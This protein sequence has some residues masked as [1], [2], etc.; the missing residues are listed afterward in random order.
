MKLQFVAA[1]IVSLLIAVPSFA[2]GQGYP[3]GNAK[4]GQTIVVIELN[5]ISPALVAEIFGGTV[6]YNTPS[7]SRGRGGY[8]DT[9]SGQNYNRNPRTTGRNR[10]NATGTSSLGR[11]SGSRSFDW[12]D[13]RFDW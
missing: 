7:G 9:S 13:S 8:G 12:G 6:I 11:G 3:Q 1:I 4:T 10:Y 2:Q 5:R